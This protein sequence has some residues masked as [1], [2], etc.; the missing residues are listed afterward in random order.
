MA[1]LNIGPYIRILDSDRYVTNMMDAYEADFDQGEHFWTNLEYN[2]FAERY[3]TIFKMS[4]L[5]EKE[6]DRLL[7]ENS[8]LHKQLNK[9]KRKK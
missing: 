8:K 3:P 5:I 2:K 7:K 9:T 6:R 4:A 1:A